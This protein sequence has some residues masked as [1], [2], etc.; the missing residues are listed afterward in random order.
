MIEKKTMLQRKCCN[1]GVTHNTYSD[2]CSDKCGKEFAEYI[3]IEA[4]LEPIGEV[5]ETK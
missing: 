4:S 1:C 2:F 5:T 3:N